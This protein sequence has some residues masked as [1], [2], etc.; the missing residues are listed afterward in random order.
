MRIE[1]SIRILKAL[2][3]C[4]KCFGT[5]MMDQLKIKGNTFEFKCSCGWVFTGR[6]G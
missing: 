4:P 6:E 3:T 2:S 1:T 5:M